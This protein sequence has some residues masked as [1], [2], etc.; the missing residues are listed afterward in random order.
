M[1]SPASSTS[2]KAPVTFELGEKQAI[3]S[4]AEKRT[5]ELVIALCGPIGTPLHE[6][7]ETL[8][9]LL[10]GSFGYTV[11]RLR[12]S[13]YIKRSFEKGGKKIDGLTPYERFKALIDTGNEL[14]A[15]FGGSILAELAVKQIAASR[16]KKRTGEG[17]EF[18]LPHRICHIIDSIKNKGELELLRS[19]YG[20]VLYCIGVFS[21]Q[22]ERIRFLEHAGMGMGEIGFLIDRDSG[23]EKPEGQKV[24]ETFPKSDYF[25]RVDEASRAKI[26]ERLKRFIEIILGTTIRTA[27]ANESAMY[28]A[29]TAACNSACLSR[30]VGAAIVNASGE[31]ISVGWN[32]VPK[33][34]GNLYTADSPND[35]R[36]FLW[37][38][39]ECH[40]DS[41]KLRIME[42]IVDLFVKKE[43]ISGELKNKAMS[44]LKGSPIKDLLEFS[45]AVHAEMHA[46]IMAGHLGKGSLA[47]AKLF[48]TT[49]PCHAC[50]R[51]IVA[52]GI[53]EVYF[54]EPYTKSL[55]TRLHSD[56]IS[57]AESINTKVKLIPFD[58]IAPNRYRSL[59]EKRTN[60]KV[61]GKAVFNPPISATVR[62]ES[63]IESFPAL[64]A[65]VV[66]RL[67]DKAIEI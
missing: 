33:F 61:G 40:N 41:E 67:S 22:S 36:C 15:N 1:S 45:R 6:V 35:H 50:A 42:G 17:K 16:A 49:Y 63:Y 13:D 20:N 39:K 28:M 24:E 48:C 8:D 56:S 7:A 18:N 11:K 65:M 31:L 47:G 25:L 46:I 12:L 10:T 51:H 5:D 29:A 14:R 4:I 32:D 58:G 66:K 57:D 38:T 19:V 9:Q 64:E 62:L 53:S 59:F 21:P 34:G 54:I 23:E 55:A 26:D 30:Q 43:L 37:E 60:R 52:A 27:T 3:E 44:A 2:E